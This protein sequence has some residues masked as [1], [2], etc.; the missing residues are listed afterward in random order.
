MR[1]TKRQELLCSNE[2]FDRLPNIAE[3]FRGRLDRGNWSSFQLAINLDQRISYLDY[4][5]KRKDKEKTQ[6]RSQF[7]QIH[8]R[9][10]ESTARELWNSLSPAAVLGQWAVCQLPT[11]PAGKAR[12]V[13]GRRTRRGARGGPVASAGPGSSPAAASMRCPIAAHSW[14]FPG[15]KLRLGGDA[16]GADP[17]YLLYLAYRS[18]GELRRIDFAAWPRTATFRLKLP[19]ES[20]HK[21]PLQ[22]QP[23]GA[24]GIVTKTR[25]PFPNHSH[26][27]LPL[28]VGAERHGQ[29]DKTFIGA[30]VCA[31]RIAD[32]SVGPGL[33]AQKQARGE[34]S[35][36]LTRGAGT[37]SAPAAPPST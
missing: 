10:S 16:L 3:G 2:P 25:A 36:E 4:C 18:R 5:P 15:Q 21:P 29:T 11:A 26:I 27:G 22:N 33:H 7:H 28:P 20:A 8:R 13:G 37:R 32:A 23:S 19:P 34:G 14:H 24:G 9:P 31:R 30:C 17:T 1:Q 35:V 12:R 6:P